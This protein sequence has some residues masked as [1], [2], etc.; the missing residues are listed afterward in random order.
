MTVKSPGR[1]KNPAEVG[2]QSL[3]TGETGGSELP[4]S[5]K[6]MSPGYDIGASNDG[7]DLNTGFKSMGSARTGNDDG[8]KRP[9]TSGD[10]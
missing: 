2:P 7:T 1:D 9:P 4:M 6:S 3:P 8:M 5:N 10:R